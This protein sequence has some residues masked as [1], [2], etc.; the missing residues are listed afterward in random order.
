MLNKTVCLKNIQKELHWRHEIILYSALGFYD[1]K[2][3]VIANI[4]TTSMN[5][6]TMM[7]KLRTF[8]ISIVSFFFLFNNV[9]EDDGNGD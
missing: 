2:I 6:Y 7:T 5:N 8:I 4:N 9:G 3:R 1:Y